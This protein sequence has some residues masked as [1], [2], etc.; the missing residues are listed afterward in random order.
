L[1]ITITLPVFK[2]RAAIKE[3]QD[4]MVNVTG[5]KSR[6]NNFPLHNYMGMWQDC[7]IF[8]IIISNREIVEIVHG[9]IKKPFRLN[10]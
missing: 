9:L 3:I 4:I 8:A 6:I 1:P 7:K 2:P 10:N 5:L